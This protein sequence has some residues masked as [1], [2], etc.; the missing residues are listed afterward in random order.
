MMCGVLTL[1][2]ESACRLAINKQLRRGVEKHYRPKVPLELEYWITTSDFS[3]HPGIK[4]GTRK[5]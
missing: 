3:G 2:L 5:G 4:I 1:E